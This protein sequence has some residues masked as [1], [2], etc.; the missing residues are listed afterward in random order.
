M[1]RSLKALDT[2]EHRGPDGRG[3]QTYLDGRLFM[4]HR[5]LSIIDKSEN[6]AQPYVSS[7]NCLV[8]NGEIYNYLELNK[9][10][11]SL[12]TEVSGDTEVLS[13]LIILRGERIFNDLNGMW[14]LVNYNQEA[15]NLLISR[16]RF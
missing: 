12:Q 1:Q 5:R 7:N 14:G 9:H 11:R 16:D 2:M 15:N 13:E 8:F 10:F 6:A 3:Y 4:G